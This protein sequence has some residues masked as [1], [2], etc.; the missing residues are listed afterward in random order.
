MADKDKFGFSVAS[1]QT[2]IEAVSK[3]SSASLTYRVPY[4]KRWFLEFRNI[5]MEYR[6]DD[7]PNVLLYTPNWISLS[8]AKG[9]SPLIWSEERARDRAKWDVL[10]YVVAPILGVNLHESSDRGLSSPSEQALTAYEAIVGEFRRLIETTDREAPLQEFLSKSPALLTL[11]AANIWSQFRLG[12]DY[13]T[14]YILE[15]GNQEYVLIE[16]EA[17]IRPLYTKDG[18]PTAQLSHAIQQVED[19]REWVESSSSYIQ[20]KLP[21]IIDPECWVIIGRKLSDEQ[22]QIKW[23]RKQRQ[24][25]SGGIKLLT[26]DELLDRNLRQLASLRQLGKD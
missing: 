17:S 5:K 20:Q 21:G 19:W 6:P 8:A 18:N 3:V 13:I 2:I 1:D 12:D 14:D 9:F 24:L 15:L 26:Y 7:G 16:I 22:S 11:E 25:L 10:S 23:K 4:A